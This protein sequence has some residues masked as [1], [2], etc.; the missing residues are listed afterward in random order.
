MSTTDSTAFEELTRDGQLGPATLALLQDLGAQVTRT[1]S[2]PPPPGYKTWSNPAV[3][4]LVADMLSQPGEGAAFVVSCLAV[5]DD[6]PSLERLLVKSVR[7]YLIDDAKK[8]ER[9]KLRRRLEGLLGSDARFVRVPAAEAGT[10]CWTLR[11]S[12][13]SL[14]QGDVTQLEDAA[15]QLRG[16]AISHWNTAGP[17]PQ[18]TKHALVTVAEAVLAH[19]GGCVRDEDLARVVQ[20]RFI[21]LAAHDDEALPAPEGA[22][23]IATATEDDPPWL[24]EASE[25]RARELYA[26]LTPIERDAVPLLGGTNVDMAATLGVGRRR[27]KAIAESL[28]EKL[29]I[30]TIDDEDRDDVLATLLRLCQEGPR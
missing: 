19:A 24:L 29:R 21:L 5:A 20:Q 11:E 6:Q 8:T 10:A 15:W 27:S 12:A 23:D 25:D 18:G 22:G 2:F 13:R 1:E 9:G 7:N 26:S 4:E 16:V 30:A 28:T 17:T 3:E 14:W